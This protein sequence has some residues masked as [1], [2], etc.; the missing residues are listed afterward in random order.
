MTA[1]DPPYLVDYTGGNHPNSKA[2]RPETK[3][4]TGIPMPRPF[5][6][7]IIVAHRRDSIAHSF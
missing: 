4:R 3:T 5:N 2:N 7:G 1:T 6:F